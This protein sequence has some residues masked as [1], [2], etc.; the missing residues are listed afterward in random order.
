MSFIF[1]FLVYHVI[2]SIPLKFINGNGFSFQIMKD[3]S[4]I[5]MK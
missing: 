2:K 1:G 4:V 3:G 5:I